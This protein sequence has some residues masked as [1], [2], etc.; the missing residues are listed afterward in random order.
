LEV[1]RQKIVQQN[2]KEYIKLNKNL[3]ISFGIAITVSAIT[4][5]LLADQ[6]SYLNSSYTV[7]VDFVTF[8]SSFSILFYFDNRKRYRLEG[9]KLDKPRL[10]K[11]LIKIISSLGI[12]EIVYTTVRWY[13]QYYF[14]NIGY[15]PYVASV[16]AHV[17]STIVYMIVVNLGV[18]ITRLYKHGT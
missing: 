9:G 15:E 7:I 18:K 8:Y 1:F 3:I 13:L 10:K 12:G 2:Y 11:D 4:A 5:Q 16:I 17:V 6:Q 14:L